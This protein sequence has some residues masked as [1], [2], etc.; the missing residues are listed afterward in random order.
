LSRSTRITETIS[1][2][3][4]RMLQVGFGKRKVI[5]RIQPQDKRFV[6]GNLFW[7]SD[8]MY[9]LEELTKPMRCNRKRRYM[10]FRPLRIKSLNKNNM[11]TVYKLSGA[12]L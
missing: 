4:K 1:I 6:V 9:K 5:K 8:G 3:Q 2:D 10:I 7:L 12:G 11:Y